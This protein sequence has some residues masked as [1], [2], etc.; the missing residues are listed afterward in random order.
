MDSEVAT[1]KKLQMKLKF[2][3]ILILLACALERLLRAETPWSPAPPQNQG[4]PYTRTAEKFAVEKIKNTVAVFAGSRYAWV[5]GFKVRLDDVNW[6]DE[7][8]LRDGK[9]YVPAAFAGVFDLAAVQPAPAPAYLAD[10]WVYSLKLLKSKAPTVP[11]DGK[12]YV[13][14]VDEAQKRGLKIFQNERGLLLI[15]KTEIT[16]SESEFNLLD[17]VIALFDTPEKFADPDIA[18]RWIP[19]LKRQGAWTNYVKVTPEQLKIYS[20]PEAEWPTAPKS[21]YDFSGFNK[22]LLG[23]RVPPPGVYPRVLFS[24]ED[25][26][27]LAARVKNSK[28]GQKSL[29]E[30]KFLFEQSFWDTNTS[31]G[32]FFQK[33]ANNDLADL[34]WPDDVRPEL[35]ATINNAQ[36]TAGDTAGLNRLLQRREGAVENLVNVGHALASTRTR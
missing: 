11:I 29:I 22:K 31:D 18:T 35:I 8:V 2:V 23:S 30:M 19:A 21:E 7:A 13:A 1:G 34:Q 32:Q 26:P 36:H 27:M 24:P 5:H 3:F 20:G 4:L 33:L 6:R 10:R 17:S 14:L 16:F 25:L 28:L 12:D 15:S 9:I